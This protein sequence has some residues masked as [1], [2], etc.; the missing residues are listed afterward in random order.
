[1]QIIMKKLA[2]I[3][4]F[5]C[6]SVFAQSDDTWYKYEESQDYEF[7]LKIGSFEPTK[8]GGKI[9]QKSQLKN[10]NDIRFRIVEMKSK[11]CKQGYGFV[12]SYSLDGK[13]AYKFDYVENGGTIAQTLATSLCNIIKKQPSV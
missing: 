1:M 8:E 10:G 12:Y 2:L 3:L 9:I 13:L 5:S 11:D 7:Y 6:S 4:L